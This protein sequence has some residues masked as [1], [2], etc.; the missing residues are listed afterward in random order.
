MI[1]LFGLLASTL[2]IAVLLEKFILR[3]EEKYVHTFVLNIELAK[4]RQYHA[5][6]V[7]KFSVQLWY[8]HRRNRDKHLPFIFI[9]RKLFHAI[10][11]LQNIKRQQRKLLDR[12][13]GVHEIMGVQRNLIEQQDKFNEQ[14]IGIQT[15]VNTIDRKLEFLTENIVKFDISLNMLLNR[16]QK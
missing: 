12:C 6:N 8:L 15:K 13:I 14:I 4:K 5:A 9:Q 11:I 1:G 3:R 2:V 16:L 7:V 10:H